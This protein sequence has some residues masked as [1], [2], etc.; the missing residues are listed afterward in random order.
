MK[1]T[2][3]ICILLV[4][5]FNASAQDEPQSDKGFKKENLFVGGNFGLTIGDFTLINISPQV[6]YQFSRRLAAGVGI[7]G[8]YIS[9]KWYDGVGEVRAKYGIVGLNIFG[10]LQPTD[11]LM[12]QVQPEANYSFGNLTAGG[13]TNKEDAVIVPSLLLGGGLVMPSGRGSLIASV[14]FDVLQRPRSP[15]GNR[16]IYNVGYNFNLGGN[17]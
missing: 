11:F 15:Y 14:F 1:Q 17:R 7:N 3:L 2:L 10:R 9:R 8:Q 13:I 4:L 16:P 5:F 6:G 12:V